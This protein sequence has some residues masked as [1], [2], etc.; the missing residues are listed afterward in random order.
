MLAGSTITV[1]AA[2]P[3]AAPIGSVRGTASGRCLDVPSAST[4]NGVQV[5][6]WDCGAGANQEWNYTSDKR[7]TVYGSKCLD[8][9]GNGTTA[10]TEVVIWDCNGQTNQQWNVHSDGTITGV[11]SGLPPGQPGPSAAPGQ[12]PDP[13]S[14]T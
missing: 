6:L 5:Q 4:T 1:A 3:A 2:V 10:G 13:E 8:A 12:P 9:Y 7:L 14:A 11:A